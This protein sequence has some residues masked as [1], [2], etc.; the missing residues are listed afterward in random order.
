ME[1]EITKEGSVMGKTITRSAKVIDHLGICRDCDTS[2]TQPE[3]IITYWDSVSGDGMNGRRI[4]ERGISKI[5][6]NAGIC[7]KCQV[8]HLRKELE[9]AQ[10]KATSK[11]NGAPGTEGIVF[12]WIGLFVSLL[13]L[14]LKATRVDEYGLPMPFIT[15][16]FFIWAGLGLISLICLPIM[17]ARRN[18]LC[19]GAVSTIDEDL[20]LNDEALFSKYGIKNGTPYMKWVWNNYVMQ[21]SIQHKG[22]LVYVSELLHM[23]SPDEIS[24]QLHVSREVAEQLFNAARQYRKP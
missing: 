19:K 24:K 4:S 10:F 17:Y 8:K 9:Q 7:Q 20:K 22:G 11:D 3:T 23:G 18:R 15:P 21:Q 13:A 14:G 1:Q 6:M 5:D 16:M 2:L 12:C